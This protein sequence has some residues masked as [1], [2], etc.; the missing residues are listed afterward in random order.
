MDWYESHVQRE[1][2]VKLH[3]AGVFAMFTENACTDILSMQG[4]GA[5]HTIN[6]NIN[7]LIEDTVDKDITTWFGVGSPSKSH[8][9]RTLLR[10]LRET[11]SWYRREH[12]SVPHKIALRTG[13]VFELNDNRVEQFKKSYFRGYVKQDMTQKSSFEEKSFEEVKRE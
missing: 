7:K 8:R 9:C 13:Q 11:W 1:S 6:N 12:T 4:G 2:L 5:I 3:D 10:V